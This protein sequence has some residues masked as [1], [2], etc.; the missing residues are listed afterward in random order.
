M[1]SIIFL[2]IISILSFFVYSEYKINIRLKKDNNDLIAENNS[3][4]ENLFTLSKIDNPDPIRLLINFTMY[5]A[6]NPRGIR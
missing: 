5:S 3:L 4:R 6:I 1:L 2:S